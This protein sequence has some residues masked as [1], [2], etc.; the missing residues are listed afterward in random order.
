[1]NYIITAIRDE[2]AEVFTNVA[3][4]ED[5][6]TAVRG[7]ESFVMTQKAKQEG[8]MYSHASDFSL[9]KI[10][11]FDSETGKIESILPVLL[12]KVGEI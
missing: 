4:N 12:R 8:L 10:A 3:I 1:M 11:D 2:V 9:Y 7:L 6:A 5:E